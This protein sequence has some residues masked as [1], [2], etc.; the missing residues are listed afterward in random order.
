MS[1]V[2]GDI[3]NTSISSLGFDDTTKATF[4]LSFSIRNARDSARGRAPFA[5]DCMEAIF[6]GEEMSS[7]NL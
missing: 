6:S 7:S 2:P 5:R 1:N 4:L 3:L